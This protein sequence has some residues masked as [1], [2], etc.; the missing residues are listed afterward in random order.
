[1][2]LT[3]ALA[4]LFF[5]FEGHLLERESVSEKTRKN[6]TR[7]NPA[8]KWP[9]MFPTLETL[10]IHFSLSSVIAGSFPTKI[11]SS[12]QGTISPIS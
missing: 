4:V 10:I 5:Y 11:R 6:N 3:A 1:M 9:K 7:I 12:I 8:V 2:F